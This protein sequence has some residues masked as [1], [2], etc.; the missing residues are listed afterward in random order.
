MDLLTDAHQRQFAYLRLSVIDTCNFR[1]VY[2]LPQGF[3]KT[4]EIPYL[5]RLEIRR[6][7]TAFAA[8]GFWKIRLTGGEPTVRPD[9][10]DIAR[11]VAEISGITRVAL[12]T[13]GY[14]LAQLAG[15]LR[16]AGVT[17][18]NVSVDSLD[19][20]RF[21]QVTGQDKLAEVLGGIEAALASG[22]RSVKAN[23]VLLK[24]FFENDY[25]RFLEWVRETP[26]SVRFIE[27][28]RTADNTAL[29]ESSFVPSSLLQNRLWRAGWRRQERQTGDGPAVVFAHPEYRGTLG[30]IAPY[31]PDFCA[32]CNRLRVTCR[33]DLRL[34]LFG[35]G[36]YPLRAYLQGDAQLPDLV[37]AV[38]RRIGEKTAAHELQEGRYGLTRNFATIGG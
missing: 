5:S 9:I 24:G 30:I 6:L 31:A 1:C 36:G 17:D 38:R 25:E 12:S 28:M 13:N 19:R 32:G 16:D 29:F 8:M 18:V 35:E 22:F 2:C 14:R 7:V 26:I 4:S 10:L 21:A 33:G 34:C 37:A 23:A 27:L 3:K 15:S 20:P 11:T